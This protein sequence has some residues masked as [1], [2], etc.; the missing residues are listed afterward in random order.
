MHKNNR[1][2]IGNEKLY[3]KIPLAYMEILGYINKTDYSRLSDS[4][5]KDMS[6][7]LKTK[8][9]NG[10]NLGDIIVPAFSLAREASKRVLGMKHF[11]VQVLSG[12]ALHEGLIVDM[13]TGEGKTLAAV[14]PAYLNGLSGKGVHILTFNDYLAQRDAKWMGPVYEFLGLTTGYIKQGMEMSLKKDAYLC[15]IMYATAK[16]VGFDYLRSFLAMEKDDLIQ[17]PFNYAIIDEADSILIDEARIPMVIAGD[18]PVCDMGEDR[19]AKVI[20]ELIPNVH[21][22]ID[23]YAM[24]VMLTEKGID[25]VED[26]LR[27]GN[28]YEEIN[29]NLLIGVNNAL[30]AKVL[31]KKDI[32]YIVRDKKIELVDE[33][34]GRISDNRKWPDG[35]QAALEAKEGIVNRENGQILYSVTT[36]N[37]LRNYTR[38]SGMSGTAISSENQ[39]FDFYG[40]NCLEIP[41]NKPCIRKDMPDLV[42]THKQAKIKA[43]IKEIIE[44]HKTGRPILIGTVSVKE[45]ENLASELIKKGIKCSV[46]N[47]KN[48][49]FEAGIIAK[50]G[51]LYS[52]TVSTNMAGRGTDIKLGGEDE[53]NRSK[54]MELGGLY[55]IVTNKH[56]SIRI[57]EQLKGRAGRQGDPG[58]SRFFISLEDDLMKRYR[59]K[60]LIPEELYPKHQEE[61]LKNKVL[62]RRIRSVQKIIEGQ[63]HDIKRTLFRYTTILDKQRNE[64]HTLRQQI[65]IGMTPGVF[66]DKLPSIYNKYKKVISESIL[67]R[68]ERTV[69]LFHIN[70]CWTQYLSYISYVREGI[71]LFNMA[72]KSPLDEYHKLVINAYST[73]VQDIEKNVLETIKNAKITHEGINLHEEGLIGPSS[74]WT[75]LVDDRI[76]QLGID[77]LLASPAA[78]SVNFPLYLMLA[79]YKFFTRKKNK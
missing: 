49:E 15:D 79:L 27:C 9:I 40:L 20:Y 57:D 4:E 73:I 3:K 59:L 47:A 45:S 48:D 74:T 56:E 41:T 34:T 70:E 55:V 18:I 39:F 53:I 21:Y 46:L 8:A 17:R 33:F 69:W 72:G 31:L 62:I 66:R 78:A 2:I 30:H 76:E 36:Q 52:V 61:P 28:L 60:E 10:C 6:S 64:I 26:R 37:F 22:E 75:Y 16:E 35:L 24:N 5:L 50:A 32:D 67:D 68:I 77:G 65:L 51:L 23:E 29:F 7:V 42:F 13:K 11:D 58:C 63:N 12:I 14:L 71:H 43:V 54:I 19:I 25:Y 44:V 38:I 1:N